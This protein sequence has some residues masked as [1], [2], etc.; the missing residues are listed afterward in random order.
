MYYTMRKQGKNRLQIFKKM[1][2]DKHSGELKNEIYKMKAACWSST[3]GNV[4]NIG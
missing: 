1:W 2:Y 4:C 3:A